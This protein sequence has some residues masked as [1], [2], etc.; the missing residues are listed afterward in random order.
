MTV[1]RRFDAVLE[2]TKQHVLE[3]KAFLD[4]KGIVCSSVVRF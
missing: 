2:P 1:L 4:E 3:M